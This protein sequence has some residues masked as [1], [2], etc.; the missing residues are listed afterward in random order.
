[1][2][3]FFT[4]S[5]RGGRAQQPRFVQILKALETYGTVSSEHIADKALGHFGET[6]LPAD[7]VR[8]REL[9]ALASCDVVV[10]EVTSPSLGVGYLLNEA[11]RS[12]KKVVALYC[13]DSLEKLSSIVKGDPKIDVR[14]YKTEDD[15]K[16]ALKE[17]LG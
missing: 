14:L 6:A 3:I 17:A 16:S 1:M 13:G 10:A 12:E 15:I 11:T 9:R 5:V 4:G 8:E 7:E 2:T